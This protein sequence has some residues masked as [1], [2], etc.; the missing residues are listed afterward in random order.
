MFLGLHRILSRPSSS[1]PGS[2]AF[3][4]MSPQMQSES[5]EEIF[6][7]RKRRN[8]SQVEAAKEAGVSQATFSRWENGAASK[9]LYQEALDRWLSSSRLKPA[10]PS[11][12]GVR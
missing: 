3:G 4:V 1:F 11:S 8:L 6:A 10:S 9:G 7:E 12:Q 5:G 2:L